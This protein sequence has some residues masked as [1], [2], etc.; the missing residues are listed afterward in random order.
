M[1]LSI[2]PLR[3]A[4][5]GAEVRG[6]DPDRIDDTDRSRLRQAF[7]DHGLLLMKGLEAISP[8]QHVELSRI[9]GV[10]TIHPIPTIRLAEC[11]EIIVLEAEGGDSLAANDPTRNEV[12]GSIPWH[13]DLTYTDSPSRGSLLIAR[14]VPPE[15]GQ[16]G[17]VDTATV[18]DALPGS[19]RERIE[20]LR[21]IHSLGP[22]QD[23]LKSA[24]RATADTEGG[25]LPTFEHVVH[26][27]VHVHP[28][29]GRKVLNISP[30]FIQRIEGI[31]ESESDSLIE[32]LTEFATQDRFV[33]LHAWEVGDGVLWDN[34]RTMH[35]ATG[36]RRRHSRRMHR[37]TLAP[38]PIP[39]PSHAAA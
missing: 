30:A 6:L 15:M 1:N 36:H 18:Y 37:T 35:S 22:L 20:G 12:V 25:E 16:T 32:A 38:G 13:S 10:P 2:E 27:L 4:A 29:S 17:Y 23:S 3:D 31:A 33:H 9:F 19:L 7:L 26:P 24:A 14:V 39:G 5:F 11:P 8:E 21:A 34:W 28:D